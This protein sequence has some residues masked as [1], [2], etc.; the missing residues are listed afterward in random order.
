MN[1]VGCTTVRPLP[2]LALLI[3]LLR[4]DARATAD[5]SGWSLANDLASNTYNA[6]CTAASVRALRVT[7]SDER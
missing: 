1:L 3:L 2:Y 7:L 6:A 5:C 4:P